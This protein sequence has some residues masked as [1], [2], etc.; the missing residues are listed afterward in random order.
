[1]LVCRIDSVTDDKCRIELKPSLNLSQHL[2]QSLALGKYQEHLFWNYSCLMNWDSWILMWHTH[3]L[4]FGYIIGYLPVIHLIGF[5]YAA[6]EG[7]QQFGRKCCN[8]EFSCA[9][10]ATCSISVAKS[11]LAH[12]LK[13]QVMTFLSNQ[14]ELFQCCQVSIVDIGPVKTSRCGNP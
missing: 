4:K 13:P 9:H 8:E 10:F 7:S 3:F 12:N 11:D 2:H 14:T 6:I 5:K 1:M